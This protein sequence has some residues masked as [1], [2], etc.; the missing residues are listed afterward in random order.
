MADPRPYHGEDE[1]MTDTAR[2]H[3]EVEARTIYRDKSLSIA[4]K[5]ARLRDLYRRAPIIEITA[6][7]E[8]LAMMGDAAW[9]EGE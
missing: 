3:A 2:A 1:H 5:Q 9:T 8:M 4:E 7:G 6:M